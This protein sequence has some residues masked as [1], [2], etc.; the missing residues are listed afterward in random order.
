MSDQSPLNRVRTRLASGREPYYTIHKRLLNSAASQPFSEMNASDYRNAARNANIAKNTAFLYWLNREAEKGARAAQLLVEMKTNIPKGYLLQIATGANDILHMAESLTPRAQAYHFLKAAEYPQLEI[1]ANN[2]TKLASETAKLVKAIHDYGQVLSKALGIVTRHNYL[3]KGSSAVGLAGLYLD[4][5]DWVALGQQGVSA[6]RD[7]QGPNLERGWGE[8]SNYFAYAAVNFLPFFLALNQQSS[9]GGP[10][11][12]GEQ[13]ENYLADPVFKTVFVWYLK[14]RLPTGERPGVDDARYTPFYSGLLATDPTLLE[15]ATDHYEVSPSHWAWDWYHADASLAQGE[16][17]HTVG[18]VDLSAD[19]LIN[20]DDRIPRIEPTGEDFEPTQI[21]RICGQ[22]VFRSGWNRDAVYLLL[23][24]EEKKMAESGGAHEHNDGTSFILGAH[25]ELLAL[26]P[27]YPGWKR[28]EHTNKPEHHN[29]ILI[30]DHEPEATAMLDHF[31]ELPHLEGVQS[32]TWF[33]EKNGNRPRHERNVLF[34]NKRFFVLDDA[35]KDAGGNEVVSYLHVQGE[36]TSFEEPL[37][38]GSWRHGNATLRV[39]QTTSEGAPQFGFAKS[40]HGVHYLAENAVLPEHDVLVAG[41]RGNPLRFLT[42]LYPQHN[43]GATPEIKP[44][45]LTYGNA[46]QILDQNEKGEKRETFV[47]TKTKAATQGCFATPWG[48]ALFNGS[49]LL[50]AGGTQPQLFYCD[51]ATAIDLNG[52]PFFR[53]QNP[54]HGALEWDE[55]N[56][57]IRGWQISATSSN[58]LAFSAKAAPFALAGLKQLRFDH[59]TG[60]LGV[61]IEPATRDFAIKLNER[62]FRVL[63]LMPTTGIHPWQP[64]GDGED[65]LHDGEGML[66]HRENMTGRFFGYQRSAIEILPNTRYRLR[67]LVKTELQNGFVAAGLGEWSG[68]AET[69]HDFGFVSGVQGWQEIRGEWQSPPNAK[70]I[71]VHLYGS[72]NFQGRAWFKD[73]AL[74]EVSL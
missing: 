36:Q 4:R 35:V 41:Q 19:M 53:A 32:S 64:Y 46:F 16:R 13:L 73:A 52:R 63:D 44:V 12:H 8:G 71:A 33:K 56:A 17:F 47:A 34:V 15:H 29:R 55:R 40:A 6:V 3:L 65:Y 26:D 7:V 30:A 18:D 20:F 25:G 28:R 31:F 37:L 27:G 59:D 58:P 67:C 43:S 51:G 48:E 70:T 68:R 2:L 1:A 62:P 11:F 14:T 5:P 21:S 72:E 66:L 23:Q 69:H 50:I 24:G 54:F 10:N 74:E 22:A 38:G 42:I 45:A 49:F 57:V 60:M 39:H 9:I 61:E